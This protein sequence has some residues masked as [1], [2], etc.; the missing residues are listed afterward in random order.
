M[1]GYVYETFEGKPLQNIEVSI[2]S[3]KTITN[4]D[5]AYEFTNITTNPVHVTVNGGER[6]RIFEDNVLLEKGEN[7]RDFL[8]D[9]LHP[10][11]ILEV[12]I[13]D[14]YSIEYEI[15]FGETFIRVVVPHNLTFVDEYVVKEKVLMQFHPS[16]F[17]LF[18]SKES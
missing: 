13:V 17:N 14:P 8:I 1:K 11:D 7:Y 18:T 16:S 5:G 6:F 15:T 9:S 10:L 2:N 12:D 4:S 3:N